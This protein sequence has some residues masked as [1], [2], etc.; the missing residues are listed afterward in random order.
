MTTRGADNFLV[1]QEMTTPVSDVTDET[2]SSSHDETKSTNSSPGGGQSTEHRLYVVNRAG[3]GEASYLML[4]SDRAAVASYRLHTEIWKPTLDVTNFGVAVVDNF[5]YVIGGF[6]RQRARHLSRVVRYDPSEGTWVTCASLNVA[7]AKFGVCAMGGMIY[8]CGG[9]K[10][11]GRVTGSCEVYDPEADS[12]SKAGMLPQPRAN[13]ACASHRR[14]LYCAG[15]YFGNT[16]HNN[17][18]LY[19]DYKWNEVDVHYPH[20]LPA[21]L[22][23]CA[24]RCW[25]TPS[26]SKFFRRYICCLSGVM[27]K[28]RGK[29]DRPMFL[30]D[31]RAF[32]YSTCISAM[33]KSSD[34]SD[35]ISPWNLKLPAMNH[36]R[37]SAGA[38]ALGYKVYVV[39]GT[40][41]ETGQP[42]RIAEY[43]DTRTGI[44]E[45][46]F[47]FRKGD[48][49][50]V[51]CVL[52]AVP[53]I[54]V[55][56]RKVAYRLKWVMW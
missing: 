7:R 25:T 49:S 15:G 4:T 47:N 19:E 35:L 37:H 42:V 12:W 2:S 28:V 46:D 52:L 14:E 39:G 32:S 16:S 27:S 23:R 20:L 18:W 31:R 34:T 10:S 41:L 30:T 48:V 29:D 26:I 50:N 22:D 3:T 51:A 1:S 9:E 6:D 45:E 17:L 44:W 38:V 56:E 21:S 8:V 36:A 24:V 11:D 43:L 13:P 40:S 55:S 5:L 53:K 54:P 33:P